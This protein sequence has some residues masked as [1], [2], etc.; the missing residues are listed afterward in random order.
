MALIWLRVMAKSIKDVEQK[1]L[2]CAIPR[3][4][5]WVKTGTYTRIPRNGFGIAWEWLWNGFALIKGHRLKH[6]KTSK[7]TIFVPFS[8]AKLWQRQDSFARIARNGCGMALGNGCAMVGE[9]LLGILYFTPICSYN[10]WRLRIEVIV[11]SVQQFVTRI[12][13]SR[14][15][16][17]IKDIWYM[18]FGCA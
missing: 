9:C 10:L 1:H 15:V 3:N 8:E 11:C 18:S 7:R 2:F 4:K 13:L 17:N 16:S 6:S 14:E 5:A 12:A